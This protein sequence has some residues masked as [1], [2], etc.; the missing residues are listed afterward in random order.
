MADQNVPRRLARFY[1][2]SDNT[3]QQENSNYNQPQAPPQNRSERK[4]NDKEE[5]FEIG[6]PSGI[7]S[8]DYSDVNLEADKKNLDEIKKLQEKNLVEK[9]ALSEIEKFKIQNKRMPNSKEEEQ[10]AENLYKQIK[11]ES[12][13]S[14]ENTAPQA[15]L[16]GRNRRGRSDETQ[17]VGQGLN[18]SAPINN[19]STQQS[20]QNTYSDVSDIK[21]LFGD[22]EEKQTKG[23]QK[24][25]FDVDLGDMNET[26]SGEDDLSQIEDIK[27]D[28]E[29]AIC[30]NCKKPTDK[31]IYCSKCG[32]AFCK[33]CAKK[34]GNDILC[35]K[36]QTKAKI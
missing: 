19:Q 24:D 26:G 5:N 14:N 28:D 20:P 36:C 6:R 7:P 9:L 13:N 31:T 17:N 2:N 12:V 1:R 32:T 29:K 30:P 10:I 27:S 22:D 35:P 18:E 34:E 3:A 33:N 15:N 16:R 25:E 23:K 21:D 8:M 11:E 4:Q